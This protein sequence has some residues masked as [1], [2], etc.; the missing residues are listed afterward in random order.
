MADMARLQP[1]M[2][3]ITISPGATTGTDFLSDFPP[4]KKWLASMLIPVL[5]F[6]GIMHSVETGA[7]RYIDALLDESSYRSGV[8]YGSVSGGTGKVDDQV[9]FMPQLQNETCQSN[10]NAA[11]HKFVLS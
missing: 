8:F 5:K 2:R 4:S 7:K 6:F 9:K 11:I 10:A 3:F 1:N